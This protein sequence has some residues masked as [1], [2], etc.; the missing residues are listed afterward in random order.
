V[1]R[2][3]AVAPSSWT[4][5]DWYAETRL[6][7]AVRLGDLLFVSGCSGA[8]LYPDDPQAQIRQAY[9]Y[10]GEVLVAGGS[11]WDDVVS[12]T[13]YHVDM[14]RHIDDVLEIH[15]EFVTKQPYPAWSG[16]GVTE[17]FQPAAI[18]EVS[19]IARVLPQDTQ[20]HLFTRQLAVRQAWASDRFRA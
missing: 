1:D 19:V 9:R 16:L 18:L 17:L 20:G 3:E 14:Q 8:D 7:P 13:T 12:I 11:S 15:R 10:V 4:D 2:P 5:L 6:S